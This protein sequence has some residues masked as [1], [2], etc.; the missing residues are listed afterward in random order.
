[1]KFNLE[2]ALHG[3]AVIHKVNGIKSHVIGKSHNHIGCFILEN[4]TGTV[5]TVRLRE[6]QQEYEMVDLKEVTLTLPCP[7]FEPQ[8]GM[9]VIADNGG[10]FVVAD[11]DYRAS[12]HNIWMS[13]SFNKKI[14][15]SGRCFATKEKAQAWINALEWNRV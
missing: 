15:K 8:E 1:M 2:K 5:E 3:V 14:L 13:I 10:G 12:N 4:E 11:V 6:L 9:V 7:L